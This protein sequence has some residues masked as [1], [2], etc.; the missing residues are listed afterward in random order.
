MKTLKRIIFPTVSDLMT[1]APMTIGV[2][3]SIADAHERMYLNNIHHLVVVDKQR[4]VGTLSTRQI[5]LL[6]SLSLLD[7]KQ[8]R[9]ASAM[10]KPYL[11]TPETPLIEV[12]HT[13]EANRNECVVA[14]DGGHAAGILTTTDILRALRTMLLGIEVAPQVEPTH[15]PDLPQERQKIPHHTRL[16]D[17]A[18]KSANGRALGGAMNISLPTN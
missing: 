8:I 12:A 9:V 17:S 1:E 10:T 15:Q 2:G 5:Y 16:A 3:L 14:V 18:P 6:S 7:P 11:C 13:M 4:I